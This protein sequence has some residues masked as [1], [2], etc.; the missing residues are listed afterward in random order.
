[1]KSVVVIPTSLITLCVSSVRDIK[2]VMD[3]PPSDINM[4]KSLLNEIESAIEIPESIMLR[5]NLKPPMSV[6]VIDTAGSDI[7]LCVK[8]FLDIESLVEI[9]DSDTVAIKRSGWANG[10][11]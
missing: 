10:M 11:E 7:V 9:A 8:I 2:S 5:T 1:M 6:S 4:E 3:E